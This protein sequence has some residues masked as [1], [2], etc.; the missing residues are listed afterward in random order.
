VRKKL[1]LT[2]VFISLLLF[3]AV[4]EKVF[5]KLATANFIQLNWSVESPESKTYSVKTIPLIIKFWVYT[6]YEKM[7]GIHVTVGEI[8]YSIDERPNVTVSV[9]FSV[10]EENELEIYTAETVLSG[11][12]D[13]SHKVVA[14]VKDQN[15][16][17]YSRER[18][19]EVDTT[20]PEISIF[21]VENKTCD[22]CEVPLNFMVNESVLKIAYSLDGEKNVSIAGNTTLIGVSYGGHNVTVYATD[23][24]GNIGASETIF[25]TI[26]EPPELFPTIMVIA[27]IA[28]GAIVGVGLLIYFKKCK[29]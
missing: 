24:A 19:F 4:A 18:T 15:G 21:S 27:P 12:S 26:E 17:V 7:F 20:L 16:K 14:Y 29:H 23:I 9:A 1:L 8:F 10:D 5:V 28:S 25:F 13:G 2:A 3:S 6:Y 22:K 11:L